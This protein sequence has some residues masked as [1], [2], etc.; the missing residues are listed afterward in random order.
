MFSAGAQEEKKLPGIGGEAKEVDL[1]A[2]E[3]VGGVCHL[4]TTLPLH[5]F[6]A[7]E[8]YQGSHER[9]PSS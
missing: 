8:T 6:V 7:I 2:D 9:A 1:R 5:R 4:A 3:E